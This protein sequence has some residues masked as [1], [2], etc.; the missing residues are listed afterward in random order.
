MDFKRFPV[1]LLA[2][3]LYQR[4]PIPIIIHKKSW[5][6]T[7]KHTVIPEAELTEELNF[8]SNPMNL[9]PDTRKWPC[10]TIFILIHTS[11][12]SREESFL[13][14]GEEQRHVLDIVRLTTVSQPV[15]CGVETAMV[16][17]MYI[18]LMNSTRITKH[19]ALIR[20]LNV[21]KTLDSP[22]EGENS[23]M[24]VQSKYEAT[25]TLVISKMTKK[26]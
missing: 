5:E 13:V 9:V 4:I 7:T 25:C 21:M 18:Y 24:N 19:G 11:S 26:L 2:M 15:L 22:L 16:K 8:I 10:P 23:N 20:T 12:G 6:L 3:N 17:Y 14:F 1:I